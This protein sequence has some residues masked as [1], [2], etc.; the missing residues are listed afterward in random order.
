MWHGAQWQ[1]GLHQ[2]PF[3]LS[4]RKAAESGPTAI[5][6]RD[7]A[8]LLLNTLKP[9]HDRDCMHERLCSGAVL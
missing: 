5:V 7:H 4:A 8:W 6:T 1:T 3:D 2:L 9:G